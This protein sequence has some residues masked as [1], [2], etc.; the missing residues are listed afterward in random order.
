MAD[1]ELAAD[2]FDDVISSFS[3]DKEKNN[4]NSSGF[5]FCR[6]RIGALLRTLSLTDSPSTD[7]SNNAD[8]VSNHSGVFRVFNDVWNVINDLC[9][10]LGGGRG[11]GPGGGGG[12]GSLRLGEIDGEF[13]SGFSKILSKLKLDMGCFASKVAINNPTPSSSSEDV[14]SKRGLVSD[15]C[16]SLLTFVHALIFL[17]LAYP[18]YLRIVG[19]LNETPTWDW[20]PDRLT[21]FIFGGGGAVVVTASRPIGAGGG[22]D[23]IQGGF[24]QLEEFCSKLE[25]SMS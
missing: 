2:V 5:R 13:F 10:H 4:E 24:R 17:S 9:T 11:G 6:E 18:K 1:L 3:R 15:F 12:A 21:D 25:S 20:T 14:S 19:K 22:I 8:L 23:L 16:N 7:F